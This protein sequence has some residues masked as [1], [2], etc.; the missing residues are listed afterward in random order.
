MVAICAFP[1]CLVSRTPKYLGIILFQF[2]S[3]RYVNFTRHGR[4]NL[5]DVLSKYRVMDSQSKKAVMVCSKKMYMCERHFR[6]E[7]QQ[8]L[9]F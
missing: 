4:K 2:P 3:Q 5:L 9:K 6:E 8:A 7:L 1:N